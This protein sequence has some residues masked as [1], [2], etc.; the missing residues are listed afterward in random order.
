MVPIFTGASIYTHD[1]PFPNSFKWIGL[2]EILYHVSGDRNITVDRVHSPV[3]VASV[4]PTRQVK[5]ILY[6]FSIYSTTIDD[7]TLSE[8]DLIGV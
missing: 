8:Y 3:V 6:V 7:S 5:F 4:R 1:F 2:F